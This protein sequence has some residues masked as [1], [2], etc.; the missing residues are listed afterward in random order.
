MGTSHQTITITALRS[1]QSFSGT[2]FTP[3]MDVRATF[4][5]KW[6][7]ENDVL[8]L[9]YTEFAPQ[10]F[11]VPLTDRNRVEQDSPD[12][13]K[14]HTLPQ[15][16]SVDWKRLRFSP[17]V[18]QVDPP[19]EEALINLTLDDLVDSNSLLEW[20]GYL[21]E[22]SYAELFDDKMVDALKTT[23]P[24]K[25]GYYY[26]ISQCEGLWGNG[27][28]Q[29][30]LLR[31]E[32][33]QTQFFLKTAAEGYDYFDS[34]RTAKLIRELAAKTIP[35]MKRIELLSSQDAPYAAFESLWAEV[36]AYDKVYDELL[37]EE[38]AVY[39][40]LLKDI[41]SNPNDYI[42]KKKD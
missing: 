24:K 8:V 22:A 32:I 28:L 19:S 12:T 3:I 11:S 2:Y 6:S 10:V 15:G 17:A 20:I 37:K 35:W 26:A 23:I 16:T 31:E 41:K 42:T 27:G 5:G 4:A 40:A 13:I 25:A 36:D 33:S 29:H 7:L 21:I 38:S 34:P 1:D 39:K 9:E 18:K 30:V 14:L